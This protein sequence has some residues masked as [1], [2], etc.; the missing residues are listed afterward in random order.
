MSGPSHQFHEFTD[1]YAEPA[2]RVEPSI[3]IPRR[4]RRPF[5]CVRG[6]PAS[7]LIRTLLAARGASPP[8]ARSGPVGFQRVV[9][10][11]E[12]RFPRG[13]IGAKGVAGK[14]LC[15]RSP[16]V[17]NSPQATRNADGLSETIGARV[18]TRD[19][20]PVKWR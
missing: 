3:L 12:E 7:A 11:G 13:E 6:R 9:N 20:I 8:R 18:A 10:S 5:L 1:R 19:R 16:P 15:P 17:T 4:I 2:G 14:T